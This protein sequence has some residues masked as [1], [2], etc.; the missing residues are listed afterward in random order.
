[1]NRP[2]VEAYWLGNE[3]L[4]GVEARALYESLRQR[5]SG[6]M[7]AGLLDLVLGK[8]PAAPGRTRWTSL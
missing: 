5:F 2:V 4:Q 7:K 6:K 1:V 8:A 3:L